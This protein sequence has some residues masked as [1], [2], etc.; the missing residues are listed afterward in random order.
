MR[1]I[2]PINRDNLLHQQGVEPSAVT[3]EARWDVKTTGAQVLRT[4]CAFAND[5]LHL[6][7]GYIIIGVAEENGRAVLPPKGLDTQTLENAQKWIRTNARRID[8]EYQP[9]M[10]VKTVGERHIL[11]LWAPGSEMRPHRAPDGAGKAQYRYYV[12]LGS[13][14][15]DAE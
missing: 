15:V 3:F 10:A 8:P 5:L 2:L 12:R 11:V 9:V 6:N 4:L 7:G 1:Q 14:T 13:E